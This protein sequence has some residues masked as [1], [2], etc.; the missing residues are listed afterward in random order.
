MLPND[1]GWWRAVCL[2][3][4]RFRTVITHHWKGVKMASG[5]KKKRRKGKVFIS[6]RIINTLIKYFYHL[7]GYYLNKWV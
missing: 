5:A 1:G 3:E 2:S 6:N 4:K 7:S